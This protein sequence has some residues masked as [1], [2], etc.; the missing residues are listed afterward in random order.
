MQNDEKWIEDAVKNFRNGCK[1]LQKE[2]SNAADGTL[3]DVSDQQIME[4]I[5]PLLKEVQQK[6][7]ELENVNSVILRLAP[8][9]TV[10]FL[11]R[12]GLNLF[13]YSEAAIVGKPWDAETIEHACAAL[14]DDFAPISDMRAS[15]D[16]RLRACQNL[17][18][19][20]YAE[21]RGDV[22]ETV[23]TYGRQR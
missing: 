11:N 7:L 20:F 10:L 15:A 9:G 18:R 12:F 3:L 6:A 1:E 5:E 14:Q 19:R 2:L 21:T 13:G 4:K 23:Y 16:I 22:V 8:D 17:L